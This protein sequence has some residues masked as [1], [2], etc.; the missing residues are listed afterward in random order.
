MNEKIG[1]F[2]GTFDPIH[3]GHL[4]IASAARIQLGL[5]QVVFLPSGIP[6]HKA[7]INIT[8]NQIRKEMI[9][10]GIAPYEFM[11]CSD[12]DLNRKT[13]SY[14]YEM[15][16]HFYQSRSEHKD[17]L[18]FL[19]GQDSLENLPT[20]R[21]AELLT[22]YATL[23]I[24]PRFNHEFRFPEFLNQQDIVV[25]KSQIIQISSTI[26]RKRVKAGESL[27]DFVPAVVEKL[28]H[29]YALYV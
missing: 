16:R 3:I 29:R 24:Y 10:A 18:Y 13:P 26:I 2:G 23:V 12:F 27:A 11:R 28:I 14:T 17:Q 25:L 9:L 22:N 7:S 8:D 21:H 5:N 6:P 20:W 1:L 4:N 19:M 15:L